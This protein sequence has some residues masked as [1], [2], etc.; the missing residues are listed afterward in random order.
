MCYVVL[1]GP[2]GKYIAQN[3]HAMTQTRVARGDCRVGVSL[4]KQK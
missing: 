1:V 3:S 4:Y 2:G